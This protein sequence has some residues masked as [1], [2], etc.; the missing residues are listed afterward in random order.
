M[1]QGNTHRGIAFTCTPFELPYID[2][3]PSDEHVR[4]VARQTINRTLGDDL[5]IPLLNEAQTLDPQ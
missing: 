5:R 3:G 1:L 4:Y 2:G